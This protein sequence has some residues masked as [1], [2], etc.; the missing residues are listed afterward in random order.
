MSQKAFLSIG[1]NIDAKSNIKKVKLILDSYLPAIAKRL[2][3]DWVADEI[4]FSNVTIALGKIQ[5]LNSILI[6]T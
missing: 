3:D 5:F 6:V 1:S 2:G 4:S